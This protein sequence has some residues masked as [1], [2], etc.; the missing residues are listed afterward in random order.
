VN[1]EPFRT[2]TQQGVKPSDVTNLMFLGSQQE[3][4]EAFQKAGWS[5]AAKLNG[6]S[7]LETF[8]AMA[9]NRGCQEA[10]VSVLL[11]DG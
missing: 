2:E 9:E 3:L 1:R 8:R 4:A 10:P 6:V 5:V 11:L 7:K